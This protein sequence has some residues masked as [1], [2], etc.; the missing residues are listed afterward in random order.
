MC[1]RYRQ[2]QVTH[3]WGGGEEVTY[4]D[5]AVTPVVLACDDEWYQDTAD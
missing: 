5:P 4:E 2:I 3:G 1:G